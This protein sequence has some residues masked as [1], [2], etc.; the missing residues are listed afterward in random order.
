MDHISQGPDASEGAPGENPGDPHGMMAV[1]R[2]DHATIDGEAPAVDSRVLAVVAAARHHGVEMRPTDFR[3]TL[4]EDVPSAA[5]LGAWAREA[6]LYAKSDRVRWRGL[7]KLQGAQNPPP[8][9]VLLFNDGTAALMVACDAARNVVWLRDPRADSGAEPTPIDEL[10]LTE[11]WGGDV[12]LVRTKRTQSEADKPFSLGWLL[13]LVVLERR[14]LRDVSIASIAISALTIIPPL[15]VMTV[16]D[17]VVVHH[18]LSTLVLLATIL[19]ITTLYE[20]ALGYARREIVQVVSSRVDAKLNMHVFNRLLGLP[21]DYFEK[22]PAGQIN[23]RLSQV[24][25][26]REFLTGKLM[27]TFLDMF[28]LVFLLPILFWMEPTLAWIVLV[29]A[30]LITAV[31]LVF[32]PALRSIVGKQTMAESQKGTTMIETVHGIR[33]VKSLALEPQRRAEWDERTA[34]AGELK[35]QAGRLSNWPQTIITPIESFIQRGV[36]LLG[37][38][39]AMNDQTG[40]AV[41]GLVAFMML[42]SRVTQPLVGLARL[43]EDFEDVRASIQ[44]VG[45]VLNNPSETA[46]MQGGMRPRFEGLVEFQELNFT[47][48]GSKIPALDKVTVKIPAGTM[49]GVVGRSGSGKSTLTRLLQGINREYSGFLKIDGIELRE[50][51][52]THLR[53]S[54]GVVLQDNFL[55]R[56]TVRDNIISGRPG[57]TLDDVVRAARLAGAEEFIERLPAG[58]DTYIEEGSAN[59]SGGQRQRLAIARAVIA[60][61]KLMILDEATSALDPESEALVNAN[62][63]RLGK[64]RTMVIVSHRLSSLLDCDQILVMD[65]GSVVDMAPHRVLLERCS[66]YRTLWAQQNRHMDGGMNRTPPLVP[67]AVQGD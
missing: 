60:N 45:M 19:A 61:P 12:L 1:P 14:S 15:L 42:G 8:P 3:P 54:F 13:G 5:S 36:I 21:L 30:A 34:I 32:L 57:L 9:L 41:G 6:G 25:K 47:Y 56:G 37:A 28:T 26:V 23:Y 43:V 49:L 29:C 52:L 18:S 65:R 16:V 44:Q 50:I 7:F 11:V 58:Y 59:L 20:T 31:I 2:L 24:W 64:G 51:N 33:T 40:I 27:G 39:I 17:R 4:G 48:P 62:L 63:T 46:A 35:L 66:I 67:V 38:Y 10:R 22:N 55:F 53:R